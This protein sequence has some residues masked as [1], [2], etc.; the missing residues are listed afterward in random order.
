MNRSLPVRTRLLPGE[1][2]DSWLAANAERMQCTWGDMLAAVLPAPSDTSSPRI[3]IRTLWGELTAD[4]QASMSQATG[5]SL[6]QLDAMTLANRFGDRVIS[7]EPKTR[8]VYTPWGCVDRQRFCPSCLRDSGGRFKLEWR[9]PWVCVCADHG[10]LLDDVC[11]VCERTQLIAPRWFV[12]RRVP[13]ASRCRYAERDTRS[14]PRCVATLANA[15]IRPLRLDAP[16]VECQSALRGLLESSVVEV[17]VYAVAPVDVGE[18]LEDIRWLAERIL[19]TTKLDQLLILVGAQTNR[20]AINRWC[21]WLGREL[22]GALPDRYRFNHSSSS[23]AVVLGVAAALNI[24]MRPSIDEAGGVLRE[25][26]SGKPPHFQYVA[27]ADSRASTAITAIEIVSRSNKFSILDEFRYRTIGP[28]P[29]LPETQ[30]FT[31]E[32]ALLSA[33]PTLLWP[34]CAALLHTGDLRWKTLREVLARLLLTVGSVMPSPDL[35]RRLHSRLDQHRAILGAKKLHAHPKWTGIT[36]AVLR[37]YEYL[38]DSPPPIDYERRRRLSYQGLLSK[39]QWSAIIEQR[40]SADVSVVAV[41]RWL[42][43]RVS[44]VPDSMFR[45]ATSRARCELEADEVRAILDTNV[46]QALDAIA[47]Q[48]LASKGVDDEPLLWAPPPTLFDGLDLPETSFDEADPD[49]IGALLAHGLS[50]AAIAYKLKA[51]MWKVRYQIDLH[52]RVPSAS[53][54]SN[55]CLERRRPASSIRRTLHRRL[56]EAKLRDLYERKHMSFIDIGRSVVPHGS[57][58]YLCILVSELARK[59]GIA[60]RRRPDITRAWMYEHHVVRGRPMRDLAAEA[61]VTSGM[62]RTR[63]KKYG[64]EPDAPTAAVLE[65]LSLS[66]EIFPTPARRVRAWVIMRRFATTA[67][68]PNYRAA[69]EAE[70]WNCAALGGQIRWLQERLGVRLVDRPGHERHPLTLTAVGKTLVHTV[71]GIGDEDLRITNS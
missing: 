71:T 30:R 9:L 5:L 63:R 64:L 8:K 42:R 11:P 52:P 58:G 41:R 16:I 29:R 2:I 18:F 51:P 65:A 13:Q 39:R 23:A 55:T 3:G 7:V 21:S 45:N 36:S 35:E 31:R 20:T 70:G 26:T 15:R 62:L 6:E 25:I 37:L 47:M 1:A 24:V 56:P 32:H 50:V 4:E 33:V 38:C 67:D 28:L 44:G 68:Y 12:N 46:V 57:D 49:V 27:A 53:G 10:C 43:E 48:F 19:R 69:A 40:G 22:P 61:G 17:G 34:Q 54:A 66:P 14:L 60:L 59:Y